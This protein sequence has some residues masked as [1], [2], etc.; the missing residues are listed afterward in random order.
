MKKENVL[1]K[2]I[3]ILAIVL[4]SLIS[5]LGIHKRNL[6]KWENVIPG[7]K[8]SKELSEARI[9]GFTIDDSTEEIPDP[10]ATTNEDTDETAE[11]TTDVAM[12]GG[13]SQTNEEEK[14]T[15]EV[16]VNDP[17]V[18]TKENYKKSKK[19]IEERLKTFGITDT[20]VSANEKT[21]EITVTAP[22]VESSNYIIDLITK[23]GKI[24][25]ID[26]DTKEVLIGKNLIT[27]ATSYYQQSSD[28][29]EDS[30]E[31]Y[32]DYGVRLSFT[33]EGQK[34]LREIS[35]TYIATTDENGEEKQKTITV[36][37]DG[38]DRFTTWFPADSEYTE[39]PMKLYQYVSPD[40]EDNWNDVYNNCVVIQTIINSDTLPVVYKLSTGTF[41]ESDMDNNFIK[42]ITIVGL[43]V[44]AVVLL[45]TILKYK[46]EGLFVSLIEIAYIA[47][48]LL[49]IRVAGVSLAISGVLT[50]GIMAIANY[51]LMISLMNQEKVLEK[52]EAFGRFI[53]ILIPF[54]ITMIAFTLGKEINSQ[55]IGMVGTWGILTLACT[56]VASIILLNTQKEKKNGVEEN[57]E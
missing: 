38:K 3:A 27:K 17:T 32:Y 26:S 47:L 42:N 10:N 45:M 36:R 40:D 28:L 57:E 43:V 16:P 48:H 19:V 23:P 6:N 39:L 46:K 55:S 41:I 7:F 14:A 15:I 44:L 24:E 35:K 9:Y 54:A 22:Y 4:I 18:L 52:I 56:L 25:I 31:I 53:I 1:L 5:F 12:I 11:D 2:V 13:E 34:K 33:S 49:L 29:D 30:D 8:F 21:G 50:I 37:L 20:T 51:L